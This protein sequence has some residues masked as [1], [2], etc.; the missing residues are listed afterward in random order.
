MKYFILSA[1]L[2][3][4]VYLAVAFIKFDVAWITQVGSW[5]QND[6]VGCLLGYA[7]KECITALIWIGIKIGKS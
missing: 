4:I 7:M 2:T 5:T 6:R 3:I 1:G